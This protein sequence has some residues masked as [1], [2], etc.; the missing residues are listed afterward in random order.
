MDFPICTNGKFTDLD[1]SVLKNFR[2]SPG[3]QPL[4]CLL[5]NVCNLI[6]KCVT[7]L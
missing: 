5:E 7:L 1:V 3:Q 4:L 2:V 6:E